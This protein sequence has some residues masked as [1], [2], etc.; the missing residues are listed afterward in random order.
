MLQKI[1]SGGQTG[2]DRAALDAAIS[3]D[4]EYGGWCPKGRLD[5]KGTI[6]NKYESLKEISGNFK[7]DKE[8]YDARTKKNIKDSDATLIIV[9]K[10]PLPQE[11][12]DGTLLTIE[13]VKKQ[14]KLYLI[15]DLSKSNHINSE[16]IIEWVKKNKVSI[17]N[18]AGPR[19]SSCPGIHQSSLELLK[20]TLLQYKNSFSLKKMTK[21]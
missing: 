1:I 4:I 21:L 9:P 18:I 5:E 16:L 12:K 11:I 17:L 20:T 7:T 8:N 19:E 2:V 13:D 14:K 3:S 10:I 15:V 6:P